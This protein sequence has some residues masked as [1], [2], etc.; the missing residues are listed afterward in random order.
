MYDLLIYITELCQVYSGSAYMSP[1]LDITKNC[2]DV[3]SLL[4]I[5]CGLHI[6]VLSEAEHAFMMILTEPNCKA[7]R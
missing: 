2:L 7:R 3:G 4:N 5:A 6:I 1:I